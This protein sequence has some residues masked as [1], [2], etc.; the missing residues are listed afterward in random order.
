[1]FFTSSMKNL[2]NLEEMYFS[3]EF[4]VLDAHNLTPQE[5]DAI[6]GNLL[7]IDFSRMFLLVIKVSK[8]ID[9]I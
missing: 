3:A 9:M 1:M 2:E 4:L 6:I 7:M 8:G 5:L